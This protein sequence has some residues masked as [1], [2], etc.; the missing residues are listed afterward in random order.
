MGLGL[1]LSEL[2]FERFGGYVSLVNHH[3]GGALCYVSLPL[4]DLWVREP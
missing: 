3:E 4:K 2:I 1:Y